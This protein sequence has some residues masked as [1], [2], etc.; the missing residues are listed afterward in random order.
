MNALE[1]LRQLLLE[2][3]T[4]FIPTCYDA[5][6]ARMIRD[7]GYPLAFLSGYGVSATRLGLPDTGYVTLAEMV[8]QVRDMTTHLPGFP[9]I[10]DADTGYG[11]A[12]NVR[13]TV[14]EMA[15]AGAAGLQLEDQVLPK[16]C[17]HIGVKAVV[18]RQEAVAKIRAAVD[19]RE[20]SGQDIV[21]MA[22]TDARRLHGF[23]DAMER[24]LDFQAAGADIVFME[25]LQDVDEMKRFVSVMDVPTWGNNSRGKESF[26]LYL[27]R[28]TV[29]E[30]GFRIVTDPTLLFS[31][32]HAIQTH[33]AAHSADNESAYPE[34]VSFGQMNDILG[35]PRLNELEKRYQI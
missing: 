8:A 15:K 14:M 33:L 20:D 4:H 11:N 35:L 29:R 25:A 2:P 23:D 19:A 9:V 5:L 3:T 34:Q 32:A 21:I 28:K 30:I 1:R 12:M 31:V 26:M 27:D 22:R 6:S 13:R 7:A 18:S 17:G 16:R 24:C 10:A